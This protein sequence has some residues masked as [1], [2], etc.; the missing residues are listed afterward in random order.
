MANAQST[1][2]LEGVVIGTSTISNVEGE[3]GRLSYRGY[4]IGDLAQNS[5]YEEVLYLLLNGELP[6]KEQLADLDSKL[7]AHR[8]LPEVPW[9]FCALCRQQASRSMFCA[10][11]HLRWP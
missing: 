8:E 7:K 6:N 11:L 9:L 1:K 10:L 5:S 2:G 3:I 4:L